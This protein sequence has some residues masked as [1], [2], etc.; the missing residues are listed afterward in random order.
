MPVPE[1]HKLEVDEVTHPWRL[2]KLPDE[3]RGEILAGW[4]PTLHV[5]SHLNLSVPFLRILLFT[6]AIL[7]LRVV[8]RFVPGSRVVSK[9]SYDLP[10]LHMKR[11]L[12]QGRVIRLLCCWINLSR[13]PVHCMM[14]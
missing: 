14:H 3:L 7:G 1:R 5:K 6:S 4:T 8:L 10:P 11:Y 12:V 2:H 13:P 9:G